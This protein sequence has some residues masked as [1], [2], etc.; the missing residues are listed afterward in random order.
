MYK[1]ILVTLEVTPT[2]RAIIDHIKQLAK[3]LHSRV[4]LLHVATGVPSQWHGHDAAGAEVEG[5]Q[6]YLNQVKAEFEVEEI[7][8]SAQLA[9]G[10]PAEQILAIADRENCDL[11][12]MS[13][14]GHRFVKDFLLGS[15]ANVV[16]HRTQIPVL[17]LRAVRGDGTAATS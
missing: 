1:T 9:C 15:V 8:A 7:R 2:D 4:V 17:L 14:H 5:D 12:A 3:L 13:T 10:D 6:A 16:R 11:I